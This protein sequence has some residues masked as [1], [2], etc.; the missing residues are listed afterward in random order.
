[1]IKYRLE[2]IRSTGMYSY[3]EFAATIELAKIA[4]GNLIQGK[5]EELGVYLYTPENDKILVTML[6]NGDYVE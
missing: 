4:R 6:E 3:G 2:K 1:M 5:G